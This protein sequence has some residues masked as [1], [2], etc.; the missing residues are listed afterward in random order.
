MNGAR[1]GVL[2]KLA[3]IFVFCAATGSSAAC[4]NY[5]FEAESGAKGV[6]FKYAGKVALCESNHTV[7]GVSLQM[8]GAGGMTSFYDPYGPIDFTTVKNDQ[9]TLKLM[10]QIS[11]K[12]TD[13][14]AENHSLLIPPA[15]NTVIYTMGG[16]PEDGYGSIQFKGPLV[17]ENSPEG[18]KLIAKL[19][20]A[21][22][23]DNYKNAKADEF[24]DYAN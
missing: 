20:K 14:P 17:L 22:K 8:I 2:K 5:I 23:F 16:R 10:T 4:K 21:A 6:F 19:K 13:I 15:W 9:G 11:R 24:L 1:G 12:G 3:F 7:A 18:R